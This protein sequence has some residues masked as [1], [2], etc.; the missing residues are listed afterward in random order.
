MLEKPL[1]FLL[2]D[3]IS[4]STP[5]FFLD[6][7]LTFGGDTICQLS[8]KGELFETLHVNKK[9]LYLEFPGGLWVGLWASTAGVKG[10]T[11]DW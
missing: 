2:L 6:N 8:R 3:P 7:P 5:A 1:P 9:C 4:I 11:P 10:S